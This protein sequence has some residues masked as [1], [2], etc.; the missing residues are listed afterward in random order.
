MHLPSHGTVAAGTYS[1]P[2]TTMPLLALLAGMP[3]GVVWRVH[4][5]VTGRWVGRLTAV[6]AVVE[7][8]DE[9]SDGFI[10]GLVK[11]GVHEVSATSPSACRKTGGSE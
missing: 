8:G 2:L 4:V 10:A 11:D 1:T 7:G 5:G 9:P 3:V 6:A